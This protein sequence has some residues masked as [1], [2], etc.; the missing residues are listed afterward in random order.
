MPMG[1]RF[2]KVVAITGFFGSLA[3][4][5]SLLIVVMPSTIEN[6]TPPPVSVVSIDA[7]AQ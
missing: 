3:S 4:I 2:K 6:E 7:D 5:V 1:R